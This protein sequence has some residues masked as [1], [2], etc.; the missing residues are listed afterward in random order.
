MQLNAHPEPIL[1][2]LG[3]CRMDL[4]CK[5]VSN[6]IPTNMLRKV[7]KAVID[8]LDQCEAYAATKPQ[9]NAS[10]NLSEIAK[11]YNDENI[12]CF[13]LLK[14]EHYSTSAYNVGKLLAMQMFANKK[15]LFAQEAESDEDLE[16]GTLSEAY[17]QVNID[18]NKLDKLPYRPAHKDD[19]K[20]KDPEGEGSILRYRPLAS[21]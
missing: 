4:M 14:G 10:L 13:H 8:D 15:P 6:S 11:A 2:F 12:H 1:D 3:Q 18:P 17:K 19:R 9:M 20:P 21:L 16:K 7:W 5:Y